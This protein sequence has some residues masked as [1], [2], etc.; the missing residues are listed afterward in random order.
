MTQSLRSNKVTE[1]LLATTQKWRRPRTLKQQQKKEIQF[2]EWK[3]PLETRF[4]KIILDCI[5]LPL[6]GISWWENDFIGG[7]VVCK[8]RWHNDKSSLKRD[9]CAAPWKEEKLLVKDFRSYIIHCVTKCWFRTI[10]TIKV[11]QT[12]QVKNFKTFHH[13]PRGQKS[14]VNNYRYKKFESVDLWLLAIYI[15]LMFKLQRVSCASMQS[16]FIEL[17][18]YFK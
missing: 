16:G 11:A 3:M 13:F 18:G 8:W 10:Q 14:K 17:E 15:F 9:M 4:F 6:F 7:S 1:G 5:C 12:W 2:K